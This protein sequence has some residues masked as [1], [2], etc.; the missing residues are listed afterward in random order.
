MSARGGQLVQR[1]V[2]HLFVNILLKYYLTINKLKRNNIAIMEYDFDYGD[3]VAI[4]GM[5]LY[6]IYG[7]LL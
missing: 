4:M 6:N 2:S 7:M 1:K 3:R 5:L